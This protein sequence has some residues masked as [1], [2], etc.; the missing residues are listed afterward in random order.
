MGAPCKEMEGWSLL[1][2]ERK[3]DEGKMERKILKEDRGK[4]RSE[5]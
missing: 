4:R 2:K 5:G 3:Y 1:E